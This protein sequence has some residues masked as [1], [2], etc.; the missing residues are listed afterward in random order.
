V[1]A[2]ILIAIMFLV[3]SLVFFGTLRGL[4]AFVV[5]EALL[6]IVDHVIPVEDDASGAVVR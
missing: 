4:V 1:I 2:D 6:L 3:F 5:I